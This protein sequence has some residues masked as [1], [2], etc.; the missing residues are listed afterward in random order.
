MK[1]SWSS[2]IL[3]AAVVGL[4]TGPGIIQAELKGTNA[5]FYSWDDD[6]TV[7]TFK[8]SNSSI[9]LDGKWHP[10]FAALNF[11]NN[12]VVPSA[13]GQSD[14]VVSCSATDTDGN[15]LVGTS[16]PWAGT[17]RLSVDHSDTSTFPLINGFRETRCWEL[18]V[19]DRQTDGQGSFEGADLDVLPRYRRFAI[20]IT[21]VSGVCPTPNAN[22]SQG[23]TNPTAS[24]GFITL[25]NKDVVAN[26]A[27]SGRCDKKIDTDLYITL[28]RDCDGFIDDNDGAQV[29]NDPAEGD[30]SLIGSGGA[31]RIPLPVGN[32]D[33]QICFFS[34]GKKPDFLVNPQWTG[35]IQA[36]IT[37][38]VGGS[39]EKTV[40]HSI[41]N[42]PVLGD[43]GDLPA[44]YPTATHVTNAFAGNPFIGGSVDNDTT[45]YATTGADGDDQN[46]TDD[47]TGV[48]LPPDTVTDTDGDPNVYTATVLATNNSGSA[49]QLCGW[50][51]F[52]QDSVLD[53]GA[54]TSTTSSDPDFALRGDNG[55]RSCI[56]IPNGT[57]NSPF[58]VS[59][60]IPLSE[61]QN[62][63]DFYF[64]FRISNDPDM[65]DTFLLSSFLG[66]DSGE[67]ED[68]LLPGVTS[69]PVSISSFDSR[70]TNDGLELTWAT[71]SETHNLG[72]HVWGDKGNGPERL[73]PDLVPS[74]S[75][76]ALTP[77]TYKLVLPGVVPGEVTDLAVTAVDFEGEEDVYGMFQPEQKY[78]QKLAPAP[79][80]WQK[81]NRQVKL[82]GQM[83]AAERK[84]QA[85]VQ[86]RGRA[87]QSN[88]D[89]VD[90]RV[91]DPGLQEITW[92][93]LADA[94]L[95]L[96]GV[97]ATDIAV[98]LDGQPVPRHVTDGNPR[99]IGSALRKAD[100][101][102]ER[103][104][105]FGPASGI[106]FWGVVPQTPDAIYVDEYVYRISVSRANALAT[107][108]AL[109]MPRSVTTDH[110]HWIRQDDDAGYNF[111]S[112]L[113]DPWYAAVLR[114]DRNNAHT[115]SF[116]V[117]DQFLLDGPARVRVRVGGFT[118]YA[119]APDHHV[120]IEVNGTVVGETMFDGK[121]VHDLDYEVPA[122]VLRTGA[123]SVRIVAPGGAN[124]P[125]DMFAIDTVE[126]GYTRNLIANSDRLLI[127]DSR[128]ADGFSVSGIGGADA[129][130]YAWNGES[131]TRIQQR[132]Q[133]GGE[134]EF[135]SLDD[136]KAR[137]WVSSA[138]RVARPVIV[139][140]GRNS[141]PLAGKRADFVVIAHPAFMPIS[142]SESHPLNTFVE[143]RREQGWNVELFDITEIQASYGYGM[144]LPRAVTRF[145]AAADKRFDFE[146][147]LLVGGDSSDYTDNL[148]LGSISFIPTLYAGTT[149]IPHTPSDAL[150][151]DIDGDGLA[152]KAVGRWPVRTAGD[153][154]AV[155]TKTLQ[156]AAVANPRSALWVTDSEDR[157]PGSFRDQAERMI[158]PLVDSNWAVQGV[159][160]VFFD[161]VAPE[162]GSTTA[163]TARAQIFDALAQ[164][165]SLTGFVGH[166]SPGMWTF[167]GLLRPDDISDL[168][169]EG[170]PTLIGTMACYTSYFV[171]PTS[172]SLAHR[173]MNGYRENATGQRIEG[174]ANGAVAIHGAATLSNYFHN[175]VFARQVLDAQLKG[176]TLGEAVE[177]ARSQSAD[178]GIE[179]LVINW[180]LLGD[181]TLRIESASQ[182]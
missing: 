22:E 70:Y 127:E 106:R 83:R 87:A 117:D 56:L 49:S 164:G 26:C 1:L 37:A 43:V 124:A 143:Q 17:L 33:P 41:I 24:N 181:P 44:A 50:F 4:L 160:R 170:N 139:A 175:E 28:D 6:P 80:P 12:A 115:V 82:R 45:S 102:S 155:V 15:G 126:L 153:L 69:L 35:N 177:T 100:R 171:S 11:D 129:L 40:N 134:I 116:E 114:A 173:F 94:G 90:V 168:Y 98:T 112:P 27:Q 39:G 113:A 52:N 79:I 103:G 128:G 68:Y 108:D 121:T 157:S 118:D 85:G 130:V 163:A 23:Y 156:W 180:T 61:R 95:D 123:N 42:S 18:A 131:L 81:V 91:S 71:V 144:P 10:F 62:T 110:L 89:Y 162:P 38:P 104:L 146:H 51:D 20:D 120:Q 86:S 48:V 16:T 148:G 133:R 73:T 169:N 142:A 96:N 140:A 109:G 138:D 145:L 137:Y 119:E 135:A 65:F 132:R 77:R 159:D 72:F 46:D 13:V 7:Q 78:G 47:E 64:R 59:W 107:G 172:D 122:S 55:E 152:D 88:L 74:D 149:R 92:K 25:L 84:R 105:R 97:A 179:D 176:L 58:S 9:I 141:D 161:D 66:M 32:N 31:G 21:N 178:N 151:A 2:R 30:L 19:C 53:N 125:F 147:V 150:M 75:G 57:T 60:T 14:G 63:G 34:E 111:G 29:N 167:Q 5:T 93:M 3:V 174:V 136:E 158:A 36:R 165:R 8:N 101:V 154:D 182:N 166:G 99:S 76:D 67:V 54:N